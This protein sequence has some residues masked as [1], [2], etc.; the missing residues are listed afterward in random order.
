MLRLHLLCAGLLAASTAM[1]VATA[2]DQP[3]PEIRRPAALPQADG[4]AH[5]LR[6]IP[7]ACTRLE[8]RFTGQTDRPYVLGAVQTSPRCQA[9]ARFEQLPQPPAGPGWVLNDILRVPSAA[10]PSRVAVVRVWRK[11]ADT[12]APRMDAQGKTRIY[13]KDGLDAAK[14]GTLGAVP[15]YAMVLN[16]EGGADC[17]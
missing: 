8:G 16:V 11:P 14:S 3:L 7:E 9:R 6:T 15:R 13:L 1:A 2:A 17:R 12:A 5:T 4:V 10:C